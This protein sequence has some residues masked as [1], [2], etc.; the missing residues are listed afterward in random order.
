MLKSILVVDDDV[1][2]RATLAEQ[3]VDTGD[4]DIFEA[5]D[6]AEAIKKI[7]QQAYDL[8]VLDIGLPDADGRDLAKIVRERG[9]QTP[10]VMLT[11]QD[12]DDDVV[13]G[14][15]AGAND[16]VVKPFK[17]SVLL[18]RIRAHLRQHELS[19]DAN[20]KIGP[21]IFR[22]VD[23]VLINEANERVRLTEKE[24]NI[25]KF[26]Y[27]ANGE[28]VSRE[29]LLGE[30]WGY[31]D[32]ITTHTLE[33]HIYRLRQKVENGETGRLILTANGG[34]KLAKA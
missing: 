3:L 34:Y 18:A 23:K 33:T 10:I 25:L 5:G 28:A 11:A 16:Y 21:Y 26:L 32:G 27:R 31:V 9:I 13:R 7:K 4:F 20:L 15:E 14:L 1:D 6:A 12:S 30:V 8:I 29:I 19:E 24:A 2:L 17:I 22:P